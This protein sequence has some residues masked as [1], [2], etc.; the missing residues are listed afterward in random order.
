MPL[1]HNGQGELLNKGTEAEET[2]LLYL[3]TCPGV[4][5][6]SIEDVRQVPYWQAREVDFRV[7]YTNGQ[8]VQREVKYDDRAADTGNLYTEYARVYRGQAGHQLKWGWNV[9]TEADEV[10]VW[11]PQAR[12]FYF[13]EP[14]EMLVAWQR[15]AQKGRQPT[16][17]KSDNN[18]V[19][20]S[21]YVPINFI[22]GVRE[23]SFDPAGSPTPILH[24]EAL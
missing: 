22:H 18:C 4:I 6:E 8:W 23:V 19:T 11:V 24:N 15:C 12:K 5:H 16:P 17:Y 10:V 1:F 7:P 13:Y 20:W 9:F 21:L 2:Y 14:V 3:Q